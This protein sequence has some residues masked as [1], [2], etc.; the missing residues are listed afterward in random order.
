MIKKICFLLVFICIGSF[1]FAQAQPRAILA[2]AD[3]DTFVKNYDAIQEVLDSHTDELSSLEMDFSDMDEKTIIASISKARSFPVSAKLRAALA[4]FKLGNNAFEKC[5]VIL[6]GMSVVYLE[7]MV[8]EMKNEPEM[9][10]FV[11]EFDR[12]IKPIKAAIHANDL[13]LINA[14]KDELLQIFESM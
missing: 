5:M 12:Q 1:V 3:I 6:F 7:E 11:A 10:E 9:K 14:Q 2:K 13:R 8:K 4:P